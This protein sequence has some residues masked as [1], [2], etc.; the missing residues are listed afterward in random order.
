MSKDAIRKIIVHKI[1]GR[2]MDIGFVWDEDKYQD[3]QRKHKVQLY[4]VVSAFD[5]P[6]G[7]EAPDPAGHEDRWVCVGETAQGRV[8]AIIYSEEDLPLYR[9][10]TAFDAEGRW[11]DEYYNRRGV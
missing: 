6:D 8:L 1:G 5:N 3:V 10:I 9:L 11:L 2:T 4:E 7:Y